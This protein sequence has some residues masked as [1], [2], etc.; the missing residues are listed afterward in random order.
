M[1]SLVTVFILLA[2]VAFVS[3]GDVGALF[4][5]VILG[6]LVTGFIGTR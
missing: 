1:I 6:F 5:W 2:L 4:A 3:S